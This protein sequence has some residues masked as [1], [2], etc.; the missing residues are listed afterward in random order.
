[1][2]TQL[3]SE[4]SKGCP[5]PGGDTT[6]SASHQRAGWAQH[7]PPARPAP[8]SSL[9]WV[10]SFREGLSRSSVGVPYRRCAWHV[11][12]LSQFSLLTGLRNKDSPGSRSLQAFSCLRAAAGM[13]QGCGQKAESPRDRLQL[14]SNWVC[15]LAQCPWRPQRAM[16]S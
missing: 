16:H 12:A 13:C 3:F 5:G 15:L 1:M 8:A 11:R 7:S 14:G 2:C 4:L 9:K 10:E 6:A